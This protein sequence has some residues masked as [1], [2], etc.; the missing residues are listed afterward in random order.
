MTNFILYDLDTHNADRARP[1][2]M[3][4]YRLSKIAGKFNLDL[5]SY[6]IAKCKK[7]ILVF[8]GDDCITKALD[9][10]L[11]LIGDERKVQNKIVEYNLQL[12]AHNGSGFDIG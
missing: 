11:K 5:T 2:N 8:D 9:F 4:F 3:T 6:E 10:V 1:Y 7:D 12:H